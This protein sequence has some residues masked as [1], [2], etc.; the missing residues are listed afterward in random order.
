MMKGRTAMYI[1]AKIK[2]KKYQLVLVCSLLFAGLVQG[3]VYTYLVY[4]DDSNIIASITSI[5]ENRLGPIEKTV[6][7]LL[8]NVGIISQIFMTIIALFLT[9]GLWTK[10]FSKN[11][12]IFLRDFRYV[13]YGVLE[14]LGWIVILPILFISITIVI[15]N[16]AFATFVITSMIALLGAVVMVALLTILLKNFT[17]Y[18]WK[19]NVALP[20][21]LIFL[22]I[23]FASIFAKTV[24][25]LNMLLFI[26][27]TSV[28]V[29]THL[30]LMVKI[31]RN[32]YV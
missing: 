28:S 23:A 17:K 10:L 8:L 11:I 13:Y 29:V 26:F 30:V 5:T 4:S 18:G 20:Y 25:S 24:I 19:A 27:F 14:Y 21:F 12:S 9:S 2:Q 32:Q 6:N 1:L 22:G 7:Y 3:S 31:R 15:T 16:S